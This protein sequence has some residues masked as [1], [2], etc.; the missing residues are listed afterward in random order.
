MKSHQ[1]AHNLDWEEP[2]TRYYILSS[3]ECRAD[4]DNHLISQRTDCVILL[5]GYC[6]ITHSS[7][8]SMALACPE[9]PGHSQPGCPQPT[10]LQVS[11]S[12]HLSSLNF[13]RLLLA[14]PASLTRPWGGELCCC[15]S[16]NDFTNLV[17]ALESLQY[18]SEGSSRVRW[19]SEVKLASSDWEASQAISHRSSLAVFLIYIVIL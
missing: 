7:R 15:C 19:F 14:H 3:H 13:T 6:W 1:F 18:I 10:P 12:L 9:E 17:H 8:Q 4:E 5:T 16:W 2:K 11:M